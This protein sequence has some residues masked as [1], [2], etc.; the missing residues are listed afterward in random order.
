MMAEQASE[1]LESR[2]DEIALIDINMGC[3][4]TKVVKKGEGSGADARA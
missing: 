4:V 2:A 3:P 1:L